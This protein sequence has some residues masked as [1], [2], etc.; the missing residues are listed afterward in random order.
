MKML[1]KFE[2]LS[3]FLMVGSILSFMFSSMFISQNLI[4]FYEIELF[5]M[6]SVAFTYIIY[7]DW[8]SV[9]FS[10]IVLMISSL[11]LVYSKVY[12]GKECH[13]FLWLTVLFIF[14]MIIM[15]FSPS[16]LGVLLGWDGLGMISYCLVIYYKSASSYNSGFITAATNRL[17]DSML[18]LSVAWFSLSGLFIF[19]ESSMI[20]FF[21]LAC[22]TK[23]AQVPFNS[24]LPLAMAAPTPISSL[25]HSSTLVTAGVYLL[26]RFYFCYSGT[27][28]ITILLISSFLT[29]FIAGVSA[30]QEFDMKRVVALSTL[31]Q[32]GFMILI[33]CVG[34]PYIAFFHLLVHALFKA[35][36][37]MCAGSIIHSSMGLQDLRKMGSLNLDLLVK[38][39]VNIS[40]L[41]L[42]GLPFSSGFYSK[43]ALIELTYFNFGGVGL[44]VLLLILISMTIA[45][46]MRL[47]IYFSLG[48][49]ILF[50][51]SSLKMTFSII[52][53]SLL[54][55]FLGVYMNWMIQ[56]LYLICISIMVKLMPLFIIMM[57]VCWHATLKLM[58]PVTWF[59]MGMLFMTNLTKMTSYLIMLSLMILKVVD[60]GWFE[61]FIYNLKISTSKASY[62][63]YK[64]SFSY[65]SIGSMLLIISFL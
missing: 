22:M 40:L 5:N 50:M 35:L 27:F 16:S 1:S 4:Y 29:I 51:E 34:Y 17:G 3:F 56:E 58:K 61:S 44:G 64:H 65:I 62:Y 30:L 25:V 63:L 23:S 41:N 39:C 2:F 60:Q 12:M 9:M 32:L 33:L 54:N 55:I 21:I 18:M 42:M 46:S 37:F 15:I 45:Y 14:F 43:D 10:S 36:L 11:I 47:I 28:L 59:V 26:I 53:L 52:I 49:W 8:M 7:L 31:G 19:F 6:N 38:S 13:Q 48:S 24:W 20:I 57:G